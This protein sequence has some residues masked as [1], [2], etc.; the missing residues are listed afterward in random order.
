MKIVV[1]KSCGGDYK[2]ITS[3]IKAAKKGDII[4]LRNG[5]YNEKLVIDKPGM[6][7][8]G[9]D[10]KNTVITYSDYAL[11]KDSEGNPIGTFKTA[12]VYVSENAENTT[13]ENITVKNEAGEGKIVGQ[14]VAL[15]T[16]GDRFYAENCRFEA[17][18]DTLLSG[19]VP[20]DIT[21]KTMPLCRQYFK[22]CYIEGN[23]D[24]IFGGG[25]SLFEDCEIY[26]VSRP[27]F[28]SGY[29]TAACTGEN[30]KFGYVFKNCI[31]TGSKPKGMAFLGR[32]WRGFAKTVFINC[33][34]DDILHKE[35]FSKWNDTDRHLHCYYGFNAMESF[36][37]T[38]ADWIHYLTD[39]DVNIYT[40]EN[41][42]GDWGI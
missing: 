37:D 40:K 7:I 9:E 21:G 35:V 2:D 20:E 27:N 30:L 32:P 24:F 16:E 8:I 31:I 12:T 1:D 10:S 5:I 23:V 6:T 13:F 36:K 25:T 38:K 26:I 33:R 39:E 42:F 41:M 22:S 11:M 15:Y 17:K 28:P 4:Y 18:Q 3:A 29:V 14:A 34:T 19:P